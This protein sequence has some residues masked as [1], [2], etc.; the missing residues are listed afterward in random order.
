MQST[1]EDANTK[2]YNVV[3]HKND[4]LLLDLHCFQRIGT[5]IISFDLLNNSYL[6]QLRK[7]RPREVE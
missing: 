4:R 3:K 2:I 1:V 5:F 7:L 6:L